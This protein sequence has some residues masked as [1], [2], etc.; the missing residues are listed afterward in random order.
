MA[1]LPPRK[2]VLDVDMNE[3]MEID[4]KD[5]PFERTEGGSPKA[6][7]W[8]IVDASNGSE[9]GSTVRSVVGSE[10]SLGSDLEKGKFL[11]DSQDFQFVHAKAVAQIEADQVLKDE[12]P[13]PV[14]TD[15]QASDIQVLSDESLSGFSSPGKSLTLD[16]SADFSAET[17]GEQLKNKALES[18]LQETPEGEKEDDDS[19]K[20]REL[21]AEGSMAEN[22]VDQDLPEKKQVNVSHELE[23]EKMYDI[24][25]ETVSRVEAL[26][27]KCEAPSTGLFHWLMRQWTVL[28]RDLPL[29]GI[30]GLYV[31]PIQAIF[32][33]KDWRGMARNAGVAMLSAMVLG[34]FIRNR[35][36]A[37][38]LKRKQ[39][40]VTRLM[41]TLMNFQELWNSNRSNGPVLRHTSITMHRPC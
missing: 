7:N 36:L 29:K 5:E 11:G 41:V 19:V 37:H 20:A 32:G 10:E 28:I 18:E 34:L 14:S 27:K 21:L 35:K 15:L 26:N 16:S 40:E 33:K 4:L 38:E 17:D 9:R 22:S 12:S 24:S 6:E 1:A 30:L 3:D 2:S 13:L 25:A 31:R 8:E 39:E 23:D